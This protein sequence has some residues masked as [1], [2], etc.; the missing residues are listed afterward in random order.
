M[1]F[2]DIMAYYDYNMSAIARSLNVSRQL[3]YKWKNGEKIP[4]HFQ[5][6]LEK[7]TDRVLIAKKEDN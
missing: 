7:L 4:F 3:V 5:C 6:T 1:K 2:H